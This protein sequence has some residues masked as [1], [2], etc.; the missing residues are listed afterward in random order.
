MKMM[1]LI[2]VV[3]LSLFGCTHSF[4]ANTQ[5]LRDGYEEPTSSRKAPYVAAF[6]K[7]DH[8]PHYVVTPFYQKG[9][10]TTFQLIDQQIKNSSQKALCFLSFLPLGT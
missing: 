2:P 3:F 1:L 5:L 7:G 4:S 10:T 9:D 8:Q 6:Q